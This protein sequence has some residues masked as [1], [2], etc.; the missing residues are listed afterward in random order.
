VAS[1]AVEYGLDE[2]G[3]GAGPVHALGKVLDRVEV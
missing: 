3:A 2:I 1:E